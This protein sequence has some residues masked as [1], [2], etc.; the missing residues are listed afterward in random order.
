MEKG[1]GSESWQEPFHARSVFDRFYVSSKFD[2]LPWD[3]HQRGM[4]HPRFRSG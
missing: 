4:E 3:R 1:M 2:W